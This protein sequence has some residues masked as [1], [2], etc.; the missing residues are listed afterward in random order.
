[1]AASFCPSSTAQHRAEGLRMATWASLPASGAQS[2]LCRRGPWD[3]EPGDAGACQ[4]SPP[5]PHPAKTQGKLWQSSPPRPRDEAQEAWPFLQAHTQLCSSDPV[6]GPQV[7]SLRPDSWGCVCV[8]GVPIQGC[9]QGRSSTGL[10]GRGYDTTATL[11]GRTAGWGAGLGPPCPGG[12]GWG[13]MGVGGSPCEPP[14][15]R[16]GP[17][18]HQAWEKRHKSPLPLDLCP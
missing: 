2:G 11:S 7:T 14:A 4:A 3:T 6:S 12:R 1:M 10:G 17:G 15:E 9:P 16:Q 5:P 13:F 8:G 18:T